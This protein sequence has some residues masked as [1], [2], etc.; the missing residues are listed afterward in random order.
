MRLDY[1]VA[2]CS[3][4]T[5]DG[6]YGIQANGFGGEKAGIG[7]DSYQPQFGFASRPLDA[8]IEADGTPVG[9]LM[10]KAET[11]NAGGF[12]WFG[13]DVRCTKKAPPITRGSCAQWNAKGAFSLLDYETDTWTLYVPIKGGTKAHKI[14]AGEDGA[15]K[16][17]IDILH[18]SGAYITIVEGSTTI[19][20]TGNALI[21]VKPTEITLQGALNIPTSISVGGAL[22]QPTINATLLATAL[23]SLAAPLIATKPP[24]PVTSDV[25]GATIESIALAIEAAKTTAL[26]GI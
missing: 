21:E 9:C 7:F 24:V 5:D 14:F 15:G 13:H 11:G 18:S 12:A 3:A 6:W 22:A 16:P 23:H 1:D 17:T 20:N 19:R 25:L 26:K 10:F 2:V 4:Q 8:T